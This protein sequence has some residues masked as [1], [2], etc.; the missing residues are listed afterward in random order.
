MEKLKQ[1]SKKIL[2][3]ILDIEAPRK[4]PE[5][6]RIDEIKPAPP[7]KPKPDKTILGPPEIIHSIKKHRKKII[8]VLNRITPFL[9]EDVFLFKSNQDYMTA[10][11]SPY[12]TSRFRTFHKKSRDSRGSFFHS[13]SLED[14]KDFHPSSLKALQKTGAVISGKAKKNSGNFIELSHYSPDKQIEELTKLGI[15]YFYD[16]WIC[17]EKMKVLETESQNTEASETTIAS[18]NLIFLQKSLLEKLKEDWEDNVRELSF[19]LRDSKG[20]MLSPE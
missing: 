3:I 4:L 12:D 7:P 8:E 20:D 11:R 14:R 16:C 19:F 5:E 18:Q 9:P 13:G 2:Y 1:F 6:I 15:S 10:I 17:L